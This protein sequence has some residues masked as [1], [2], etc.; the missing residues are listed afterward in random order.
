MEVIGT[1]KVMVANLTALQLGWGACSLRACSDRLFD[2]LSL[3]AF[4][5][6][7]G[8]LLDL[9]FGMFVLWILL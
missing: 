8:S 9:Q 6:V 7:L 3:Q 1:V 4:F 5:V 2:G